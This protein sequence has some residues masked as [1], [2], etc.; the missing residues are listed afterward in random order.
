MM[1]WFDDQERPMGAVM[2][3][4]A[5]VLR[6]QMESIAELPSD[7]GYQG[8][9]NFAV[10]HGRHRGPRFMPGVQPEPPL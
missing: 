4:Q 10:P 9:V 1:A 2:A 8:D 3:E 7:P 5:G 6:D